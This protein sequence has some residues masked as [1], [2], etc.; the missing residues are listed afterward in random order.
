LAEPDAAAWLTRTALAVADR[1]AA[2]AI[3]ATA[4][5]LAHDNPDFPTRSN[6]FAEM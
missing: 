6:S 3:A 4:E 2:E 5:R 1:C